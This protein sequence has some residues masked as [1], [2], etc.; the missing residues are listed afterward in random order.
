MTT[1]KIF[2]SFDVSILFQIPLLGDGYEIF[3]RDFPLSNGVSY[4]I[5]SDVKYTSDGYI[6][7]IGSHL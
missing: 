5:I 6:D 4:S 2:A 3:Q 1:E 7:S